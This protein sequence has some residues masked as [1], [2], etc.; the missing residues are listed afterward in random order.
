MW[1]PVRRL[2]LT[3]FPGHVVQ[4]VIVLTRLNSDT[5]WKCPE[6]S[7]KAMNPIGNCPACGGSTYQAK[8]YSFGYYALTCEH[9]GHLVLEL[10]CPR[11]GTFVPV[12]EAGLPRR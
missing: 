3:W 8:L 7:C 4:E 2:G 11:C 9:C 12:D 1:S 10:E 5:R 6:R